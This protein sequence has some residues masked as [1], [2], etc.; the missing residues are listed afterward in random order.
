MTRFLLTAACAAAFIAPG[1]APAGAQSYAAQSR[2][3][4]RAP[5]Y[6][7]CVAAQRNRQVAGAV[8]GGV[9][10]AVIGAELHDGSQ[11]RARNDRRYRRDYRYRGHR[12]YRG[13]RGYRHRGYYEEGQGGA[14]VAGGAVGAL[15][16]A[17]LGGAGIK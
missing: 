1:L 15:A 8:I 7:E 13:H 6:E 12:H 4:E 16:G 2:H 5:T 14:V 17:A 9:L 11:D 10:G 3:Y